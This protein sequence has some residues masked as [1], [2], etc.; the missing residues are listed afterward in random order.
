[1]A[2]HVGPIPSVN[3]HRRGSAEGQIGASTLTCIGEVQETVDTDI[4]HAILPSPAPLTATAKSEGL[5]APLLGGPWPLVCILAA[6]AALSLQ[7]VRSNTA[8]GDEALYLWA[9][10]L[11]IMHWLHGT[12][13]PAFATYFSGAP[14]IYPPIGALADSVG[15]LAAARILS[16]CFML[17]ASSFLWATASTLLGRRAAFFA[18]ALWATLASTQFLGAFATY[19]AMSLFL[20]TVAA[21]CVARAGTR[22]KAA[23]W[24]TAAA[25]AL[26]A[27]NAA[28]YASGIFD[29]VVLALAVI[30]SQPTLRWRRAFA[31]GATLL[32]YLSAILGFLVLLGGGEYVTGVVQTTLARASANST[33]GRVVREAWQLTAIVVVAA[34]AGILIGLAAERG[35]QPRLLLIVL[36]GAAFLV[37][38]EQAR[39]HTT[40]SLQKHVDFG[41]WFAAIAAGY[42]IDKITSRLRQRPLRWLSAAAFT[43]ALIYPAHVGVT[44]ARIRFHDWP[45]ST[46]LTAVLRELLPGT[47]GPIMVSTPDVPEY[48]LRQGT[49]WYRWSNLYTIRQLNGSAISAKMI[50][51]SVSTATYA[52]KIRQGFFSIVVTNLSGSNAPF[53]ERLVPLLAKSKHYRLAA[54]IPYWH[55]LIWLR[56]PQVHVSYH[57]AQS[58]VSPLVSILTPTA[59]LRPLLGKITEAVAGSGIAVLLFTL[60]IRFAWRRRKA[61]EEL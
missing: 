28:K 33:T 24:L 46:S 7:L 56:D 20:T 38:I 29:P 23:G 16:L 25:V 15:G 52:T 39:V 30:A 8:F 57:L 40:F 37:P 48:Y 45:N 13:I 35:W 17:A 2:E 59:R 47:S 11:E 4:I 5:W 9:G 10:H 54:V 32:A 6:Q 22:E 19:D 43:V 31:R 44:Q 51:Q 26:A 12:P 18:T 53:A 61:A 36:A 14:V 50:G 27:A 55:S 21:W 60:L 49:E 34:L 58:T 1:M 42:A 41:A 3:G